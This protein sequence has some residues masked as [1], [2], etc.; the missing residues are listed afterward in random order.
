MTDPISDMLARIRNAM[1]VSKPDVSMPYSRMKKGVADLLKQ[2]GYVEDVTSNPET[3]TLTLVLKY[4]V[5]GTPVITGMKRVSTPGL[6][7]YAKRDALPYVLNDL[8]IAILS[9]SQGLMTNKE[10]RSKGL[11]GEVL[12]NIY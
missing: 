4:E 2:E 1:M 8:G 11:G 3:H 5:D 6:R 10:A 9:T 12:C 7:V